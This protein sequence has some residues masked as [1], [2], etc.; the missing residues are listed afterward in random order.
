MQI[1]LLLHF[2]FYNTGLFLGM[3][4]C[5]FI[6]C[7]ILYFHV[8]KDSKSGK[9]SEQNMQILGFNKKN[10]QNGD[11][12]FA[13]LGKSTTFVAGNNQKINVVSLGGGNVLV[14]SS[15]EEDLNEEELLI[16]ETLFSPEVDIVKGKEGILFESDNN[17]TP[18][19]LEI[20]KGMREI[21]GIEVNADVENLV[22]KNVPLRQVEETVMSDMLLNELNHDLNRDFLNSEIDDSY[23]DDN[24]AGFNENDVYSFIA[25][26]ENE[27]EDKVSNDTSDD[28]DVSNS[29]T[30]DDDSDND[31]NASDDDNISEED[32]TSEEVKDIGE[33]EI[34]KDDDLF[35]S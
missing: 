5:I 21:Q 9:N 16:K 1:H 15:F 13:V 4:L 3:L 34:F 6:L 22:N 30:S 27:N 17:Y 24:P 18:E 8:L 11:K 31:N 28:S 25:F 35:D 2:S 23:L 7:Y 14:Y 32:D 12:N 26:N 20:L 10:M 29:D 33:T 19:E